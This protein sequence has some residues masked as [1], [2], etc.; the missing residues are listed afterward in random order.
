MTYAYP[1]ANKRAR[2]RA[3]PEL[4]IVTW[5]FDGTKGTN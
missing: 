4:V 1:D 5:E 3:H 2:D